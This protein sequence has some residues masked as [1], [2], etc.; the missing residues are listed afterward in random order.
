MY[1]PPMTTA[2]VKQGYE[3]YHRWKH[4]IT[5]PHFPAIKDG[6]TVYL[7]VSHSSQNRVYWSVMSKDGERVG[8][9]WSKYLKLKEKESI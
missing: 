2:I 3:D 9:I 4:K 6:E 7:L 1:I 5:D 8:V